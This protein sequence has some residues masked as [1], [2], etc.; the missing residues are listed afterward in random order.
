MTTIAPFR[1]AFRSEG[2]FVNCYYAA[3]DTMKDAMLLASM[4]RSALSKT[5]GAFEQWQKLMQH[6]LSTAV[7]GALGESVSFET[8]PAPEHERSGNA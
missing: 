2:D 3:A 5:P 4:R 1:L 6:I 8:I 7:D